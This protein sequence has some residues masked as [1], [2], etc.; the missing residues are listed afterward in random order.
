M[1]SRVHALLRL[2]S[3]GCAGALGVASQG[4]VRRLSGFT[5]PLHGFVLQHLHGVLRLTHQTVAVPA[6]LLGQ[7]PGGALGLGLLLQKPLLRRLQLVYFSRYSLLTAFPDLGN[8][9][10]KTPFPEAVPL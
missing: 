10:G 6:G 4:G 2:L 7:C 5:G 3:Y 1:D 9:Q 8:R